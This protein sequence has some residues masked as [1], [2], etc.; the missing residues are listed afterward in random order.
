[1]RYIIFSLLALNFV[2][3]FYNLFA[4]ES[5]PGVGSPPE[6]ELEVSTIQ[7]LGENTDQDARLRQ[8]ARAIEN[9][10]L[11]PES[12]E[13]NCSA[14][15]P[16]V[17]V[18]KAQA[19][20]ERIESMNYLV[21]LL[22]VDQLTGEHDFRVLIPPAASLEEAFRMLRE[23]QSQGIDSYVISKGEEALGISLGVF[24]VESAARSVQEKLKKNGYQ[25]LITQI[26]RLEREYWIFSIQDSDLEIEDEI[27][28][29]LQNE[30]P[31]IEQAQQMCL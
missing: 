4:Q 30:Y 23:L 7:L 2:Y 11:V 6:S 19:A 18:S 13:P 10:V 14:L 24:L 9:P 15:G 20:L 27:L 5:E 17:S 21:T 22:A 28:E 3:L 26:A 25:T 8:M 29:L 31:E 12:Q 16:F 1:M